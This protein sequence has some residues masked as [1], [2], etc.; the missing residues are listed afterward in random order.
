MIETELFD[1]LQKNPGKSL[2]DYLEQK[3]VKVPNLPK[4]EEVSNIAKTIAG[5]IFTPH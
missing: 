4:P 5:I 1:W 2:E 3:P